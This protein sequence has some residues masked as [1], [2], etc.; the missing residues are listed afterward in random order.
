MCAEVD[1]DN[2]G[3]VQYT[4]DCR[5]EHNRLQKVATHN[6]WNCQV[7]DRQADEQNKLPTLSTNQL[8]FPTVAAAKADLKGVSSHDMYS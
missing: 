4:V 2:D 3:K 7:A 8:N 6:S 5:D 1:D